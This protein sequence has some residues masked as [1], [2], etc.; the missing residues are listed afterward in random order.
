MRIM[1]PVWF[2]ILISLT[3]AYA[4]KFPEVVWSRIYDSKRDDPA[5]GIAVDNT[6]FVYVTGASHNGRDYDYRTIK[7]DSLGNIEWNKIYHSQNDYGRDIVV[8]DSGYSYVTGFSGE[9][10]KYDYRTIKYNPDGDTVWNKIYDSGND[11][12]AYGIA[13][14]NKGNIYVTGSSR[15]GENF[16]IQTIKYNSMGDTVLKIPLYNSGRN[17]IA[18]ALRADNTGY[19][20]VAGASGTELPH[21]DYRLIKY[22]SLGSIQWDRFYDSGEH[23]WVNGIAL[24]TAGFAYITGGS[25]R[26]GVSDFRT[27]KYDP[28]GDTVWNKVYDSGEDE[29]GMDVAVDEV[30]FVYVFGYSFNAAGDYTEDYRIIKYDQ[31]GNIIW[32]VIYNSGDTDNASEIC[33]DNRGY[34]YVTG[35]SFNGENNDYLT[36][37]YRQYLSIKGHIIDSE[38][39]GVEEAIVYLT[40]ASEREDTT[41]ATGYY[42]FLDLSCGERYIVRPEKEGYTFA[43][44]ERIYDPLNSDKVEENFIVREVGIKKVR[45]L[46]KRR[47]GLSIHT[48]SLGVF[49]IKYEVPI[50]SMINLQICDATGKVVT[51]LVNE[52]KRKGKYSV[53]WQGESSGIYFIRLAS[54]RENLVRKTIVLK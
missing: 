35:A 25:G 32:N 44:L 16:S 23:D 14:D 3:N 37:K 18:L 54:G 9:G 45:S 8:D 17:D 7:Y 24:D 10:P 22:D 36:I 48:L 6:G 26:E 15:D 33:L 5:F 13:K 34:I 49:D 1:R 46:E 12:K 21:Y 29:A 47:Y 52:R 38:G 51:T 30:G 39:N 50:S 41:E 27:M 40:G 43:P 11:D 4:V 2:L 42:E 19:I 53:R 31:D 20:Y 28:S